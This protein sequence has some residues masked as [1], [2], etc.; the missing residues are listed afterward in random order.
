MTQNELDK[1]INGLIEDM[2]AA[3]IDSNELADDWAKNIA[4]LRKKRPLIDSSVCKWK[5]SRTLSDF[6]LTPAKA[7]LFKKMNIFEPQ[8]KWTDRRVDEIAE[9]VL[10][11]G[12]Y[13]NSLKIAICSEKYTN[14][15]TN[16]SSHVIIVNGGNTTMSCLKYGITVP[17][18]TLQFIDCP[19]IMD[20]KDLYISI[21]KNHSNRTPQEN[22]RAYIVGSKHDCDWRDEENNLSSG[23]YSDCVTAVCAA[24][25]G[26]SY[27]SKLKSHEQKVVEAAKYYDVMLWL[28]NFMFDDNKAPKEMKRAV[29]VMGVMAKTHIIWGEE[30]CTPFWKDVKM[31][32][33]STPNNRMSGKSKTPQNSLWNYLTSS[34][35]DDNE[36]NRFYKVQY[37]ANAWA[38]RK[39]ASKLSGKTDTD[40]V[41]ANQ[42]R[43]HPDHLHTAEEIES[44]DF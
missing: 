32:F 15:M 37:A 33:R 20:V 41:P 1:I 25:Y 12:F 7:Q 9:A 10:R 8:R 44:G 31:G 13:G 18:N 2:D 29:G 43:P 34:C 24:V 28:K 14:P 11:Q 3:N 26:P 21:D 16:S 6:S 38:K 5:I 22:N 23:I 17:H 27:R 19:T 36:T 40:L 4:A 30:V 42:V 35:K 39:E